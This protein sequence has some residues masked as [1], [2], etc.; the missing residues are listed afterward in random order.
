MLLM[1]ATVYNLKKWLKFTAPQTNIKVMDLPKTKKM[2]L[3]L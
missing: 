2:F 3:C 1:A